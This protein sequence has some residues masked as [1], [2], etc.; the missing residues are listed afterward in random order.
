MLTFPQSSGIPRV[1][2]D[3]AYV[4]AVGLPLFS[5]L[6]AGLAAGGDTTFRL[7][8]LDDEQVI[9]ITE[10]A[11]LLALF[12]DADVMCQTLHA[13][14]AHFLASTTAPSA[15]DGTSRD[16][17]VASHMSP[18]VSPELCFVHDVEEPDAVVLLPDHQKEEQEDI[19]AAASAP[20]LPPIAD[21]DDMHL[22]QLPDMEEQ[23][24]PAPSNLIESIRLMFDAPKKKKTAATERDTWWSASAQFFMKPF[25]K[26]TPDAP[27]IPDATYGFTRPKAVP[28]AAPAAIEGPSLADMDYRHSEP[29]RPMSASY[30]V[31]FPRM[32]YTQ[33]STTEV[34]D[35]QP[36]PTPT[37][38]SFH[39]S[40][41]WHHQADRMSASLRAPAK[42]KT[43]TNMGSFVWI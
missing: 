25:A 8:H 10:D 43:A 33:S 13:V 30:Q 34:D 26:T 20:A 22:D 19:P 6:F 21:E 29:V 38:H 31:L 40:S 2:L 12:H 37:R 39:I 23:I 3:A 14:P 28:A 32:S 7:C 5:Q 24:A 36:P 9:W 42:E 27:S 1:L 11:A 35:E 16:V 41:S 4:G 15:A 17:V 18:E